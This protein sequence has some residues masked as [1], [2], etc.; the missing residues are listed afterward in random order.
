M[1]LLSEIKGLPLIAPPAPAVPAQAPRS[2][3]LADRRAGRAE[4]REG[5]R[6]P[7]ASEGDR[8]RREGR[9]RRATPR[10]QCELD[11]EERGQ[12]GRYFRV[13]RD[14]STFGLCT[15]TGFTHPVGT[16]LELL[17]YLPDHVREP[18]RVG[19]EVVGIDRSGNG[20]R[21]AFRNPPAEAVRRIHRYLC[22][23]AKGAA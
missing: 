7:V 4:R 3:V 15:L 5:S 13:T 2:K 20:T 23:Q 12:G 18:V 1:D 9:E 16:R 14:L 21:V 8:D 22:A 11:V 17:L 6:P 19:A 10:V